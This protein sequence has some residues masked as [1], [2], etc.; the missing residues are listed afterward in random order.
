MPT[1]LPTR[2]A[3]NFQGGFEFLTTSPCCRVADDDGGDEARADGGDEVEAPS[4]GALS[5][6]LSPVSAW[7]LCQLLL[8]SQFCA[9]QLPVPSCMVVMLFRLAHWLRHQ[10]GGNRAVEVCRCLAAQ[11]MTA[12]TTAATR[13]PPPPAPRPPPASPPRGLLPAMRTT[14]EQRRQPPPRRPPSSRCN[15]N[16][17]GTLLNELTSVPQQWFIFARRAGRLR[18][19]CALDTSSCLLG[20]CAVA[21]HSCAAVVHH[22]ATDWSAIPFPQA[23]SMGFAAAAVGASTLLL[24]AL[25]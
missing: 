14:R 17:I 16:I 18:W 22:S 25:A 15:L 8:C 12:P 24:A 4:P 23:G 19:S 10:H 3:L 9:G 20:G 13:S 2:P 7:C 11:M 1:R 5:C 6:C 21:V